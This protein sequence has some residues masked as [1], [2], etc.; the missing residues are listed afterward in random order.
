MRVENGTSP[1]LVLFLFPARWRWRIDVEHETYHASMTFYERR[2]CLDRP[3]I[4]FTFHGFSQ[5][6]SPGLY[7][8]IP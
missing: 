2:F 8:S 7:S 1:S 4:T 5:A 6:P 3:L